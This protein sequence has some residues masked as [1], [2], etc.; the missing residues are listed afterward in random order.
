M[1]VCMSLPC[2]LLCVRKYTHACICQKLFYFSCI[3]SHPCNAVP[4]SGSRPGSAGAER[5]SCTL[6]SPDHVPR[7]HVR[8]SISGQIK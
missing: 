8:M 2:V 5:V 3:F 1:Y 7:G 6:R 4:Y